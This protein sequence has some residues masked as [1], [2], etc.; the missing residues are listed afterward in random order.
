MESTITMA[1]VLFHA[2]LRFHFDVD[3]AT[4]LREKCGIF[5]VDMER[6]AT[7][8]VMVVFYAAYFTK[9][10]LQRKQGVKT[11][12]LGKGDKPV[13][14]IRIERSLQITTFLIPIVELVSIWWDMMAMP[15]VIKWIG[16]AV[17][18]IGVA[19]F[20]AGMTTMSDSW[21]AGIPDQ[22]ET[23]LVTR[24]IYR[25]SRNPAFLGFDLIYL[26]ILIA[27]PNAWHAVIV[28]LAFYLFHQQIKSEE[29][30]LEE[31]FGQEYLDYKK[32]VRRYI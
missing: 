22:K 18:A 20:I 19:C 13:K 12:I 15:S 2:G 6:Y 16:V 29:R 21:R 24:G 3:S 27:Y 25:I 7:I 17:S 14:Q 1:G 11:M 10:I 5:A 32:S 23:K 28:A 4:G 26:G 30:F 8:L 9:A 31:A